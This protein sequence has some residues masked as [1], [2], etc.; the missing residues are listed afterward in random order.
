MLF[1]G[2]MLLRK[3]LG[4]LSNG[5]PLLSFTCKII[6]T[7]TPLHIFTPWISYLATKFLRSAE[8]PSAIKIKRKEKRRLV[9][10]KPLLKNIEPIF[11][12]FTNAR[13][14]TELTYNYNFYFFIKK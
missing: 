2:H 10:L 4:S 5:L 13:E 8:S 3:I 14:L 12:K 9:C 6:K 1:L 11:S 7:I